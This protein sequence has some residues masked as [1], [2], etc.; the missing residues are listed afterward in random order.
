MSNKNRNDDR[1]R[2]AASFDRAFTESENRFRSTNGIK[3][4]TDKGLARFY[5]PQNRAR[6]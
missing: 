1:I 3:A 5:S 4:L 6:P 2:K